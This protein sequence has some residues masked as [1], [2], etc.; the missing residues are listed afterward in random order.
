[1][2]KTQKAGTVIGYGVFDADARQVVTVYP[3][4]QREDAQAHLDSL[5]GHTGDGRSK[6]AVARQVRDFRLVKLVAA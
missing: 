4:E 1:M 3:G 2:G 6:H 5:R